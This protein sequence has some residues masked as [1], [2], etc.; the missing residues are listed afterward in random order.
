MV[1]F[2]YVTIYFYYYPLLIVYLNNIA[3]FHIAPV[4]ET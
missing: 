2:W 1:R 3:C 4:N